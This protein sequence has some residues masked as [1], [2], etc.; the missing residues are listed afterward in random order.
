LRA[1]RSGIAPHD[2]GDFDAIAI[3]PMRRCARRPRGLKQAEL[4]DTR[5]AVCAPREA[6]SLRMIAAISPMQ[7]QSHRCA[8]RVLRKFVRAHF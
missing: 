3:A 5:K 8:K 1:A 2:R 6:A 7:S 4:R